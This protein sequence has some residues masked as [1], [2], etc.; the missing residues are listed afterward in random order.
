[1]G[2]FHRPWTDWI[3]KIVGHILGI[4]Q[5]KNAISHISI[6]WYESDFSALGTGEETMSFPAMRPLPFRPCEEKATG[7]SNRQAK[8]PSEN[9]FHNFSHGLDVTWMAPGC[10]PRIGGEWGPTKSYSIVGAHPERIAT[11]TTTTTTTTKNTFWYFNIAIENGH[12]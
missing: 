10:R 3:F 2:R 11:T 5:K 12:L 8:Y 1:M 9:P 6:F 4:I 7:A